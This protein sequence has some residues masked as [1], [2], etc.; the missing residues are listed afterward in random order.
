M[1]TTLWLLVLAPAAVC[2]RASAASADTTETLF[3]PDGKE[4]WCSRYQSC[5]D[6][7]AYSI[8]SLARREESLHNNASQS[9]IHRVMTEERCAWDPINDMCV[10]VGGKLGIGNTADEQVEENT[11]SF[12]TSMSACRSWREEQLL[13]TFLP[14]W[15]GT[16]LNMTSDPVAKEESSSS[17]SSHRMGFGNLTILDICL[18]GTHDTLSYDL[19]LEI[20]DDGLD[21][22]TRLDS[23]LHYFSGGAVQL[24]PGD[25]ES[26]LRDQSMTQRLDVTAQLNGGV[27]FLDV[28][29]T[30]EDQG[31]QEE[32]EEEE[33]EATAAS[34]QSPQKK[35]RK[36][37][38]D[39]K[40]AAFFSPKVIDS[41]AA[42][43][44]SNAAGF[45]K[46]T[47]ILAEYQQQTKQ[48]E[49]QQQT[50]KPKVMKDEIGSALFSPEVLGS[51]AACMQ[52]NAAGMQSVASWGNK[53]T[54][55][56]VEH[57]KQTPKPKSE[58]DYESDS[59]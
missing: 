45:N 38:H 39:G 44:Q 55:M 9:T 31:G 40:G 22:Y 17:S 30:L 46:F 13:A 59:E 16:L 51:V 28:R 4:E 47:D 8:P 23:I 29:I 54:D 58:S 26:F 7:V 2:F 37:T 18:P 57:Q 43:M 19:S 49:Q 53:L 21:M 3:Y 1:T 36:L 27:R 35:R 48:Q 34:Y 25:I 20:S 50:P 15:M 41:V 52:S 11:Y 12:I 42:Y 32:E 5:P 10:D 6:C 14:N 24:L 56:M 33:A